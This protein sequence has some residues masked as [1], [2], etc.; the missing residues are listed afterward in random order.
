MN[1]YKELAAAVIHQACVDLRK[2][3]T[4]HHRKFPDDPAKFLLSTSPFHQLLDLDREMYQDMVRQIKRETECDRG[5][6][7]SGETHGTKLSYKNCK[8]DLCKKANRDA[9]RRWRANKKSRELEDDSN[10]EHI[11]PALP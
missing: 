8:C 9:K 3:R 5:Q 2:D 1:P 4:G 6:V 11:K 7:P 10:K